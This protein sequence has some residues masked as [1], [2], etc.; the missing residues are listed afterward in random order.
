M[1]FFYGVKME[2]IVDLKSDPVFK[3]AV[4][5]NENHG[6]QAMGVCQV[7]LETR[8]WADEV[9]RRIVSLRRS[10]RLDAVDMRIIALRQLSPMPTWREIGNTIG[11]AKQNAHKRFKKINLAVNK[12]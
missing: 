9:R 5:Y 7:N 4:H 6:Y 1:P 8:V 11:M 3:H 2:R 10:G 12:G